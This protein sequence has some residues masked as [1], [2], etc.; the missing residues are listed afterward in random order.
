MTRVWAMLA[1]LFGIVPDK[2]IGLVD[3]LSLAELQSFFGQMTIG[4][5]LGVFFY[6]VLCFCIILSVFRLIEYIA[7]I[8]IGGRFI[9]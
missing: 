8:L 6:M 1:Q 2:Y 3:N 4:N 9:R 7:D 5:F